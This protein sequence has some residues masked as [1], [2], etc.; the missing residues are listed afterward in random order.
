MAPLTIE[1]WLLLSRCE[2][3]FNNKRV[4]KK[5]HNGGHK[6]NILAAI[7]LGYAKFQE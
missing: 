3:A 5:D 7:Y 4:D 1:T 2:V 6:D